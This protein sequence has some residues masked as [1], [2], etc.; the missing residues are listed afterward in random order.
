ME[1]GTPIQFRT[2]TASEVHNLLGKP[3]RIRQIRTEPSTAIWEYDTQFGKF[4][5]VFGKSGVVERWNPP[6]FTYDQ[7]R[8][9]RRPAPVSHSKTLH[10]VFLSGLHLL[11]RNSPAPAP[12]AQSQSHFYRYSSTQN[13]E[14]LE[15][16]L[17]RHRIYAPTAKELN[18][19]REARP[20]FARVELKDVLKVL[21]RRARYPLLLRLANP[22]LWFEQIREAEEIDFVCGSSGVEAL[23]RYLADRFYAEAASFRVLS[24]SK[25][26][27]NLAL[28]AKY[29]DNH[30]GYCLEFA[31][32]GMFL[33]THE[34]KYDDR[35]KFDVRNSSHETFD[36][37]FYKTPEWSN[38]EEIRLVLEPELG[39]PYFQ[40]EPAWL[41][42]IIL[43]KDMCD[44][45]Q[46]QIELW[47]RQRIPELAIARAQY[48]EYAGRLRLTS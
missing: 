11:C 9:G 33:C 4:E 43:G 40:I 15:P 41:T 8:T 18:D 26:W 6:E 37:L 25:R 31:N 1:S 19:P 30:R 5:L 44:A 21:K 2:L 13:L 14:R 17:L 38:E 12:V 47:A 16:I 28:W 3:V 29:S 42:R 32:E 34:V 20:V 10:D 22:V 35:L 48:D 36:W 23:L 39:G 46:K 45:D 27:D 24:L 7:L